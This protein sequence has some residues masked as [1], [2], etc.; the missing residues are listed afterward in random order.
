MGEGDDAN[1]VGAPWFDA[2]PDGVVLVERGRVTSINLAAARMLDVDRAW[3]LHAPLIAVLRD[4]RLEGAAAG[5]EP[6]EL[7]VRGKRVRVVP[8]RGGMVLQDLTALR[9]AESDARELL[10]VLSHELRTPAT[11]I[12]ATLDAL[13]DDLAEPDRSRFLARGRSEARRLARLLD[14]LTVDV[15]PPRERSVRLEDVVTRAQASLQPVLDQRRV[16][17]RND[18]G[19]ATVWADE[20]KVLQVVLN[21][22]ENA[23]LHGPA[24]GV[25]DVVAWPEDDRVLLEVRDQGVP[26]DPE[27]A[28][29]FFALH[30][31]GGP[32]AKGTGLGLYIVRSIATAWGG[33]AWGGPRRVPV[34]PAHEG[35]VAVMG[36]AFGVSVPAK[37][38]S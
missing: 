7:D 9:R 28:E 31:Q 2:L 36:N 14:D 33:R 3:A 27:T 13:A 37:R 12:S 29:A 26:I 30:A 6:T 4:H 10:A 1:P 17:V 8:V 35:R 21:L 11:T 16:R 18:V 23:A 19:D 34:G 25:V 20:D 15:R 38:P 32:K 22:L 5:S 24:D